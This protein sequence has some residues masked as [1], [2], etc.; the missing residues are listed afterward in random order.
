L[1]W[2][3]LVVRVA[4]ALGEAGEEGFVQTVGRVD[5]VVDGEGGEV[6]CFGFGFGFEFGL[7]GGYVWVSGWGWFAEG[8]LGLEGFGEREDAEGVED[9]VCWEG[10]GL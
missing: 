1:R 10:R 2:L 5:G 9:V 7:V 8:E 3:G 6:G 4:L